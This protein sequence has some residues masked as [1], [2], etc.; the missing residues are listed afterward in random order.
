MGEIPHQ[1]F[2]KEQRKDPP[3]NQGCQ[4]VGFEPATLGSV[5]QCSNH[6]ANRLQLSNRRKIF[7][8][9]ALTLSMYIV[10]SPDPNPRG[11][12]LTT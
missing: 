3:R 7:A 6:S 1:N 11:W 2:S 4:K 8:I 12:G 10:A 5:V 9:Y